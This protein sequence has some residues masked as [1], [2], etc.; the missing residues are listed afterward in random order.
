MI[1]NV[2]KNIFGP[3]ADARDRSNAICTPAL[4]IRNSNSTIMLSFAVSKSIACRAADES[5]ISVNEDEMIDASV[6][7]KSMS[8]ICMSGV[9][10]AIWFSF[11]TIRFRFHIL[12]HTAKENTLWISR[13]CNNK[14]IIYV[15]E[16]KNWNHHLLEIASSTSSTGHMPIIQSVQRFNEPKS[17]L[18]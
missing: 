14:A 16:P 10:I 4:H 11:G 7:L 6:S 2:R 17:V 5:L 13:C 12:S 8:C 9:G 18:N 15:L 1:N 3:T